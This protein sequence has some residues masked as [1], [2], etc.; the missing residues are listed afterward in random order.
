M[1][2]RPVILFEHVEDCDHAG[3]VL[4]YGEANGIWSIL[5]RKP[6]TFVARITEVAECF[7]LG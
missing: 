1:L 7:G 3:L 6:A 2:I 4:R 5:I